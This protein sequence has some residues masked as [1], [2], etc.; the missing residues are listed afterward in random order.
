MIFISD[1]VHLLI[2]NIDV[3]VLL[4]VFVEL[5]HVYLLELGLVIHE[6]VHNGHVLRR[7]NHCADLCLRKELGIDC[8][9][10]WFTVLALH[11]DNL[12]ARSGSVDTI[13]T[14]CENGI[15][16]RGL[17]GRLFVFLFDDLGLLWGSS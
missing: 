8:S 6:L 4:V 14:V 1:I 15:I 5:A 7:L 3:D 11:H 2:L 12:V 13:C 9:G 10:P 17:L 16:C